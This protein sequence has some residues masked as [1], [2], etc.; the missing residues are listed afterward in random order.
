MP[1]RYFKRY[2]PT[3]DKLKKNKTLSLLGSKIHDPE[4]WHLHRFSVAK[5]FFNGIFWAAIPIPLQMLCAALF[6]V[7]LRANMPLSVALVWVSNPITMPF[8][9][10]A[11]Y[12]IGKLVVNDHHTSEFQLSVEWMWSQLGEIWLPLY[13]GSLI[14]GLVAGTISYFLIL[15]IWRYKVNKRWNARKHRHKK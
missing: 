12:M 6:S 9:F 1:K 15:A 10:Y 8:V 5:A 4:L 13:V 7:P 2:L 14:S 3:P 11:N